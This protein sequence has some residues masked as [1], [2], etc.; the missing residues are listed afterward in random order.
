MS[1]PMIPQIPN[2]VTREFLQQH[3]EII[4]VFGDNEERWGNRGAAALRDCK[5]SVYGFITKKR[6]SGDSSAYFTPESYGPMY[7]SEIIKLREFIAS[8]STH[9]FIISAIGSGL[10]NRYYI[11]ERVILPNIKND[12]SDYKDRIVFLF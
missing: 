8:H 6:P 12:L 9:I 7:V 1:V 5:D 3:P 11:W 4:F 2:P 10:G